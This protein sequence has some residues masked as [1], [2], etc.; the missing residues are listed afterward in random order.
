MK[1]L[2]LHT[3][4]EPIER[5]LLAGIPM[6][7]ATQSYQ[8]IAHAHFVDV[9]QDQLAD[10]GFH[11]ASEL[12]GITREGARFFGVAEL[13][14]NGSDANTRN[15]LTVGMRSSLDKSIAPML[16]FGS[17]VFVCD[18]MAFSGEIV[19][20]RKQTTYI[21][22]DFPLRVRDAIATLSNA[23]AQ[24][25]ARFDAYQRVTL[26]DA[27][28]EHGMIELLRR[29]AINTSRME[30]LVSEW[31]SPSYDHGDK[32]VWRLF[33]AGTETLKASPVADITRRTIA[34]QALC[35]ELAGVAFARIE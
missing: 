20:S 6:P 22:R 15:S 1:G 33:N 27:D 32:A 5:A 13:A 12:Y 31:D 4:A 17:R 3:G 10:I 7:E 16:A 8:P 30:K 19:I 26:S 23:R 11:F 29:G 28:A 2:M 14:Y 24:Q 35:D 21:S 9:V 18:N 25:D 34:L